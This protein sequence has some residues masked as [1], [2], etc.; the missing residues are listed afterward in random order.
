MGDLWRSQKMQLVQLF[1][2][3]DAAHDTVD[4]LGN[5]GLVQFVDLNPSV[6]PFQ[7]NFVNEVKIADEMERKLRFFEEQV[8]KVN[9]ELSLEN[10][11]SPIEIQ[12]GDDPMI[13]TKLEELEGRFE[14]L[15]KELQQMNN[16]QEALNRNYNEVIELKYV[17]SIDEAFFHDGP[18]FGGLSDEPIYGDAGEENQRLLGAKSEQ[19]G[20]SQAIKLGFVTG[21][22]PRVKFPTFERVLFRATRGNSYLKFGEIDQSIKDPQSGEN[23]AK[24]VFIVFFQGE[25]LQGKIKKICEA[26]GA[27]LYPCPETAKERQELS[28]QVSNR[29]TDLK[30]VLE[31][32]LEHRRQVLMNVAVHLE[33]WKTKVKKEK[34]IYH[35]MNMFNYD[36]GRK[37]LIAEGWCPV[38]ATDQIQAALLRAKERSSATV[39]SILNPIPS[40]H[41]PP[42]YFKTNKFTLAFQAIVDSYG[43]PRYGEVNP[44]VLTIITFP[45]LFGVMFGDVGHGLA[46]LIF[47]AFL[48]WK[49]KQWMGQKLN[50][51]IAMMFEGRYVLLLMSFFAIY[52]GLL[53]NEFLSVPINFF[54]SNWERP[55][56]TDTQYIPK[57]LNYSYPFG[58]DPVWKGNPSE[59]LY[60][61]SLKMKMSIIL[62]VLQM[63]VGISM[64][65]LNGIHF[66]NYLDVFYEFVPQI[67]FMMSLFGYM[68]F[69]IFYK[70]LAIPYALNDLR[71]RTIIAPN[72][73]FPC[74][75]QNPGTGFSP[76]L[77][78]VLI[79]MVLG[80]YKHDQWKCLYPGQ[81]YVQ[82]VLVLLA[83]ICVPIMLFPKPCIL[84]SR[85][86]ASQKLSASA[87]QHSE[88]HSGE[89]EEFQFGEIFVHQIIE[90]I[91]FVLGSVSNTASYLRLWALSLAHSEL[92]TVFWQ[93]LLIQ[94]GVQLP[95][96]MAN[97]NSTTAYIVGS[98]ALFV[99]AS[100]WLAA[101]IA[102]LLLMESLSAFLHAL[103]LHWV[104][105]QNKFYKGDGIKF[106][107]FSYERI[108]SGDVDE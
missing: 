55:K 47:A 4:E 58:V 80:I 31:R 20:P 19:S 37:C 12:K 48:I 39:P 97:P 92:A 16:N 7:R 6:N 82:A 78:N 34:A 2:Q 36:T 90:T 77:L 69:M 93:K 65:L 29:L 13:R 10:K 61:N 63:S 15:E 41:T 74:N 104:E 51:L 27:T 21:V 106:N 107:P 50:E 25:R 94:Y 53:Y 67:I 71:N 44:G 30:I 56:Y 83:L 28:S 46:M 57:D 3:I 42:T 14:D 66:D 52:A 22:I 96:L 64:K 59:L 33:S 86:N 40:R 75:P 76:F 102:V 72:A 81:F 70:W 45:F 79:F 38:T 18:D 5:L 68:C 24:N 98:V 87:I 95:S 1:V 99:T 101:S 91:E 32:T 103:R 54:G 11:Y 17:L 43:V 105:F 26:F 108:L 100:G 85:H 88:E 49:E 73:S 8:E 9:T 62:G 23:I 84:R 60:Y 35:T 89:E